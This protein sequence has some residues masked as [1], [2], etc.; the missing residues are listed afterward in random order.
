[1]TGVSCGICLRLV[2]GSECPSPASMALLPKCDQLHGL[3][4]LCE[5][6]GECDTSRTANNCNGNGDVYERCDAASTM[7]QPP[8]SPP[9]GPASPPPPLPPPTP[10]QPPLEPLP[11]CEAECD[12][13]ASCGVCLNMI[14]TAECPADAIVKQLPKC[15]AG[16]RPFELCEGD[17]ECSTDRTANNCHGWR[18]VYV[19]DACT[20]AQGG[21][22]SAAPARLPEVIALGVCGALL[23]VVAAVMLIQRR[24]S[25][26][27]RSITT[28][29]R[30]KGVVELEQG[31]GQ[32]SKAEA[33][34]VP[35]P[36]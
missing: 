35:S 8:W 10:P 33:L 27:R 9:T 26:G 22:S 11:E 20:P 23:I 34:V 15:S 3:G 1:M 32:G 30:P 2:T 6:D 17:G 24:S 7:S 14:P 21:I 25:A 4:E 18:D 31:G 19:R 36:L 5:G 29:T 16:L 28:A 13:G 12:A